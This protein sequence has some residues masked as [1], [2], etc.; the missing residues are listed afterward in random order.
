MSKP[1]LFDNVLQ[2]TG[3]VLVI[4]GAMLTSM[5]TFPA[6]IWAFNIGS[7]AWVWFGIR[8]RA[9]AILTTNLV[10]L[11]IYVIGLVKTFI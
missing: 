2:W 1:T 6:N 5:N 9:P 10:L 8:V 4:I 3:T 7:I 11:I